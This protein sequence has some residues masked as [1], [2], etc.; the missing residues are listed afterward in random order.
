MTERALR[1]LDARIGAAESGIIV[2]PPTASLRTTPAGR[3]AEP[4]LMQGTSEDVFADF[5]TAKIEGCQD[6]GTPPNFGVSYGLE[7]DL[8]P[9]N[10]KSGPQTLSGPLAF[11]YDPNDNFEIGLGLNT[12][13]SKFGGGTQRVTGI[14][15]TTASLLFQPPAEGNPFPLGVYYELTIPSSS[16]AKGFRSGRF[17]HLLLGLFPKK[18]GS[19]AN[20][21]GAKKNTVELDFGGDFVGRQGVEGRDSIGLLALSYKRN[22]G[23]LG[24]HAFSIEVDG[25]SRSGRTP[26]SHP[27]SASSSSA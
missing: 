17:D 24:K 13:I 23:P 7:D 11:T 3:A 21:R 18:F 14:G 26:H 27:R 10:V 5:N 1:D 8:R 15:D 4:P 25:S 22:F 2:T 20:C 19:T 9:R 16:E 6:E 12:F